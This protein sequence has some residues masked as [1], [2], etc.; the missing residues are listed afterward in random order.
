M[1]TAT[2]RARAPAHKS[3]RDRPWRPGTTG[4]WQPGVPPPTP[5]HRDNPILPPAAS[6]ASPPTTPA[7]PAFQTAAS[8]GSTRHP[9]DGA[10]RSGTTPHRRPCAPTSSR[11]WHWASARIA[12]LDTGTGSDRCA[13]P[14]RNRPARTCCWTAAA[15]PRGPT[16]CRPSVDRGTGHRSVHGVRAVRVPD[17]A[18]P[19]QLPARRCRYSGA[20]HRAGRSATPTHNHWHAPSNAATGSHRRAAAGCCCLAITPESQPAQPRD[21]AAIALSA[22]GFGTRP[23]CFAP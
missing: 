19:V 17:R 16:Q 3:P 21:R 23:Q 20:P 15:A 22:H 2:P 10:I 18:T 4:C 12:P 7:P 14:T 6:P 13:T 1:P 9:N 11:R 8:A 5:A